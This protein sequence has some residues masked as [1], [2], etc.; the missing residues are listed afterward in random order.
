MPPMRR[1]LVAL[2]ACGFAGSP[3]LARDV[4]LIQGS[5]T[6]AT[7]LPEPI[8][9]K[10]HWWTNTVF[11]NEGSDTARIRLISISKGGPP[12]PVAEILVPAQRSASLTRRTNWGHGDDGIRIIHL[13]VPEQVSV[14]SLLLIGSHHDLGIAPPF[15]RLGRFGVAHLPVFTSLVPAHET[16][17]HLGIFLGELP[18]RIN[19]GIY[20]AA[21]VEA[22]ATV[23]IRAHCD[24]TLIETHSILIPADTAIQAFGFPVPQRDCL[25]PIPGGP[26]TSVYVVVTVDQ[27][28]LT[29]VS[30]VSNV[31]PPT[32][33]VSVTATR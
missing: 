18:S 12:E 5:A 1:L 19:V 10:L 17:F 29:F 20:N 2:L 3:G 32:A 26:I 27:P 16:Q 6:G 28:S 23:E 15:T 31:L 8:N 4:F 13:S 7:R 9:G 25:Q 22:S 21:A 14:E 33:S 11:F 24:D 30:N